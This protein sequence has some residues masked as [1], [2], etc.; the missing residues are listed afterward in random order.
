MF[1][2]LK[3]ILRDNIAKKIY[4]ISRSVAIQNVL[5]ITSFACNLII[6]NVLKHVLLV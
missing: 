1:A 6:P 2:T 3:R 4:S 5:E